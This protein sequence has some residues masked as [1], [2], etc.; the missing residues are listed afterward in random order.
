MLDGDILKVILTVAGSLG[1]SI[2][3]M[4]LTNA[5][6]SGW[7]VGKVVEPLIAQIKELRE[8]ISERSGGLHTKIESSNRELRDRIDNSTTV[9]NTRLEAHTIDD[10]RQFEG[11]R[12]E[13]AGTANSIALLETKVDAKLN[14]VGDK[15]QQVMGRLD[16]QDRVSDARH[17]ES[18]TAHD[19][20]RERLDKIERNGHATV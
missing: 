13:I 11:G 16:A 10:I 12:R 8:L 17:E 15:V 4:L 18:R 7:R 2:I 3:G 20:L 14:S 6:S 19:D 1:V 5:I 9:L